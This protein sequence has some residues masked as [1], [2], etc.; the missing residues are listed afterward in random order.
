MTYSGMRL[1]LLRSH[2]IEY[3]KSLGRVKRAAYEADEMTTIARAESGLMVSG[4]SVVFINQ[5]LMGILPPRFHWAGEAAEDP[6]KP[7]IP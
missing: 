1:H 4:T 7:K 5:K 6:P 2:P 3:N